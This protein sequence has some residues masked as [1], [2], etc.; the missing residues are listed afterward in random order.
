MSHKEP[1]AKISPF[2]LNDDHFWWHV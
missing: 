1:D 2:I